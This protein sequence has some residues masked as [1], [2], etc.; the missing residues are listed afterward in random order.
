MSKDTE[1]AKNT[2]LM[3]TINKQTEEIMKI[4]T[5]G[6]LPHMTLDGTDGANLDEHKTTKAK[7]PRREV[8]A[9]EFEIAA[10][11]IFKR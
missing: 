2:K 4:I 9:E 7:Q 10:D 1:K 11:L 5:S 6:E 8:T 3:K